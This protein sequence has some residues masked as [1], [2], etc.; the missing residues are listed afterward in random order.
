MPMMEW[1]ETDK[2]IGMWEWMR[3]K[4]LGQNFLRQEDELEELEE[5]SCGRNNES[6]TLIKRLY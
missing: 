3:D 1:T 5:T 6:S 4:T 2:R